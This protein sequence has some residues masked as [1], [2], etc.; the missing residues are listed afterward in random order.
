MEIAPTEIIYNILEGLKTCQL[1]EIDVTLRMLALVSNKFN[2]MVK[3]FR[4]R[5]KAPDDLQYYPQMTGI[6][7]FTTKLIGVSVV[8]NYSKRLDP[9]G[10][11]GVHLP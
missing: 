6:Y 3:D 7:T 5:N 11:N 1:E 2:D 8:W 4:D 9:K 10:V